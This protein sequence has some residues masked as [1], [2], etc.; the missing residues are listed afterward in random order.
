MFL[1]NIKRSFIAVALLT[2]TAGVA[3]AASPVLGPDRHSNLKMLETAPLLFE[4]HRL[5]TGDMPQ[6]FAYPRRDTTFQKNFVKTERNALLYYDNACGVMISG[7]FGTDS[8][9]AQDS[10]R[11]RVPRIA[12]ATS[13]VG[14]I[15]YRGGESLGD[16]IWPGIDGGIYM[17]GYADSVDFVLDARI[18]D[19]SHTAATPKSFDRE[20]VEV[21][22]EENNSGVEYA[23][24][25]RY[26]TH[27][28]FNYDW[29]RID[30]GRDV[31]HW[32]P[33]YYNN[34]TL[35]QFAL[36]QGIINF[37]YFGRGA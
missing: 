25:A 26:R 9:G 14:G 2:A 5:T 15:D 12:L 35:N 28:G 17:R 32:G 18:Y 3:W 24:Y 23:S 29:L 16:T 19:E 13:V 31:M 27:F 4:Y 37:I 33:G 6:S 11:V 36:P 10:C 1:K 34:L 22:K 21:Q 7:H 20:F 30:L 8:L